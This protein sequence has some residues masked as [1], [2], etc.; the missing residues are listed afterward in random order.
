M[1]AQTHSWN[2]YSSVHLY[3]P[4]GENNTIDARQLTNT[5][6]ILEPHVDLYHVHNEPNWIFEVT[7]RATGKPVVFDIHDWTSLRRVMEPPANEI[8]AEKFALE[9]ADGFCVPT[10]GYYKRINELTQKPTVMVPSKVGSWLFPDMPKK[11]GGFVY[12][13]GLSSGEDSNIN[14][15]YR[16]WSEFAKELAEKIP[17]YCYTANPMEPG[18]YKHENIHIAGPLVYPE[19]LRS[20]AQHSVG[21]VGSP[22]K[23]LDFEDSLPNKL[24][25]YISAGIPVIV[26]NSPEAKAYVEE[27]KLGV[28]VADAKEAIEAYEMLSRDYDVTKARWEYAM[29]A[30]LPKLTGFY[31]EV[32]GQC[33]NVNVVPPQH[34][35]NPSDQAGQKEAKTE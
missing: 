33:I 25:E 23:L 34:Q 31:R 30:E 6:R 7:K 27:R 28:G 21:I 19:M 3:N 9:H 17:V 11:V 2:T 4:I 5:V 15:A 10:N 22:I 29:E 12:A 14:Y 1:I 24:F 13:G 8:E 20:I 35:A 26:L 32:L 18:K 16:D